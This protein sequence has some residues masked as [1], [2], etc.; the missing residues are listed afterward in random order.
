MGEPAIPTRQERAE[1]VQLAQAIVDSVRNDEPTPTVYR[2]DV[3][4]LAQL[5]EL[6]LDRLTFVTQMAMTATQTAVQRMEGA[7]NFTMTAVREILRAARDG[8]FPEWWPEQR[9]DAPVT[10]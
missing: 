4:R 6:Y 1:T 8:E 7:H 5:V 10:R 2:D 9:S 3:F